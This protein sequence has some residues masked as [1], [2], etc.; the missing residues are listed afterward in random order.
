[1]RFFGMESVY[2][3]RRF[4][5]MKKT[6]LTILAAIICLGAGA[7]QVRTN[8][9]SGGFTHISTEFQAIQLADVPAKARVEFVRLPDDSSVYLIYLNLVQ[10]EPVIAPKGVKL[11]ATLP[12]GKFV[13][14]D[15]IGQGQPG[16]LKYA[17]EPADMDLL[18]RGIKSVD[19]VTGW[20][21]DDYIQASFPADELARLLKSHCEAIA[22]ATDATVELTATVSGR[23]DNLNSVLTTSN[24]VV[25]RGE[26]MDYNVL[27]SHLYYKNTGE[28]DVDLAF[29]LGTTQK[30]HIPYDAQ[31]RFKLRDGSL[32]T[33]VQARDDINFVYVYPSLD[34]LRR[35]AGVGVAAISID[36]EDGTVEDT[37]PV[38]DEDFSTAVNQ[39]L[40]LLLSLSSK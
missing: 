33:L 1:M 20:N 17:A 3:Q 37:I 13:R 5:T 30:Y 29:V 25:A 36:Y 21:P 15:Q 12:S 4:R 35:M 7:Q 27:L 14:L 28:E 8:Y 2:L 22:S 40:Q 38:S 19:I 31:V 10:K 34:N 16:R 18:C 39:Q 32:I 11:S 9:R 24:P 23:T 6:I 26:T